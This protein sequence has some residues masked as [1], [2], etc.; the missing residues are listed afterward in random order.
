MREH[1]AARK[2]GAS[3]A[4]EHDA[5]TVGKATRAG[6]EAASA[7]ASAFDGAEW[8]ELDGDDRALATASKKKKKPG[9][10]KTLAK[11]GETVLKEIVK[12]INGYLSK[13]T[14]YSS[15][16]ADAA[17]A[18]LKHL[19]EHCG[20]S[21]IALQKEVDLH[22]ARLSN[23]YFGKLLRTAVSQAKKMA[24]ACHA[25]RKNFDKDGLDAV[26]KFIGAAMG[27]GK[28]WA[29][30]LDSHAK[31]VGT[32]DGYIIKIGNRCGKQPEIEIPSLIKPHV[33]EKPE[34]DLQINPRLMP[35]GG[36]VTIPGIRLPGRKT[37]IPKDILKIRGPVVLQLEA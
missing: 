19:S 1:E 34:L 36:V 10:A 14:E 4:E 25:L 30:A 16:Q 37:V 18:R 7:G 24:E 2:V 20:P 21:T 32:V 13:F 26:F 35:G 29:E 8:E 27:S 6:A 22:A 28:S 17:K 31:N 9:L 33:V 5:P 3:H 11:V 15:A 23:F 12:G